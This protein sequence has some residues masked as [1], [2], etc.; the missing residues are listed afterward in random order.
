MYLAVFRG[1]I[2]LHGRQWAA[3][4]KA[5]DPFDEAPK[6]PSQVAIFDE[7]HL[8]CVFTEKEVPIAAIRPSSMQWGVTKTMGRLLAWVRIMALAWFGCVL[9]T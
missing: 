2:C 9:A 7:N 5:A 3:S 1:F 6:Q 4:R 8:K